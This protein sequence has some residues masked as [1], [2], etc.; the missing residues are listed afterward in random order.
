MEIAW[1]SDSNWRAEMPDT[2]CSVKMKGG[3]KTWNAV[4]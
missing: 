4:S 1:A 3:T 2:N